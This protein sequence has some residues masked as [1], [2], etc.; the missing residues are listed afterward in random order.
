M[1]LSQAQSR[2]HV[3]VGPGVA[4]LLTGITTA[5][6]DVYIGNGQ[7]SRTSVREYE[8]LVWL[9]NFYITD[10]DDAAVSRYL[11]DEFA[12]TRAAGWSYGG[13]E[14]NRSI[15]IAMGFTLAML[16]IWPGSLSRRTL[17]PCSSVDVDGDGRMDLVLITRERW[18]GK[19]ET[20][21]VYRNHLDG[22]GNWIGFRLR[23]APGHPAPAPL[24]GAL[25]RLIQRPSERHRATHFA[26]SNP[27]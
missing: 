4:R 1:V 19:H 15:G 17:A 25:R 11:M 14:K 10:A 6:P 12:R 18:P 8:P 26:V 22:P 27:P 24:S 9:H 20:L 5:Y 21:R 3:P 23:D 13:Y 16:P 2:S 7:D